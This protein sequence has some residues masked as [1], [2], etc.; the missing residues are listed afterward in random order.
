M[1]YIHICLST[2][3]KFWLA[4]YQIEKRIYMNQPPLIIRPSSEFMY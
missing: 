4:Y 3:V 2:L 1:C